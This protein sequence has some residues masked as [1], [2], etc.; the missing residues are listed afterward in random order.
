LKKVIC[1][2]LPTIFVTTVIASM[3]TLFVSAATPYVKEP[4]DSG[5]VGTGV[6]TTSVIQSGTCTTDGWS[7]TGNYTASRPIYQEK[8]TGQP[9][10]KV[11]NIDMSSTMLYTTEVLR[12]AH[13]TN[14]T[15]FSGKVS[16]SCDVQPVINTATNASG[17]IRLYIGSLDDS[18]NTGSQIGFGIA[19]NSIVIGTN[20]F[21]SSTALDVQ[22]DTFTSSSPSWLRFVMVVDNSVSPKTVTYTVKN[23]TNGKTY[24]ENAIFDKTYAGGTNIPMLSI[25]Y[26]NKVAGTQYLRIDNLT[27]TYLTPTKTLSPSMD[28]YIDY[29]NKT[30]SHSTSKTLYLSPV[31][32]KFVYRSTAPVSYG[33]I[34]FDTSGWTDDDVRNATCIKIKLMTASD[35]DET[36]TGYTGGASN[37]TYTGGDYRLV[38][39][40]N[41]PIKDVLQVLGLQ[42][43]ISLNGTTETPINYK[44]SWNANTTW[45]T[46]GGLKLNTIGNL[47]RGAIVDAVR[48]NTTYYLDVTDYVVFNKLYDSDLS[49]RNYIAFKLQKMIQGW[50]WTE[51]RFG[52]GFSIHSS[53]ADVVDNRPAII[54]YQNNSEGNLQNLADSY[55]IGNISAVI[56][57]VFLPKS[58]ND[59]TITWYSDSPTYITNDGVVTQGT[60]DKS[61]CLTAVFAKDDITVIKK[62]YGTVKA[63]V[64]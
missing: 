46:A 28:T 25:S 10:D 39:P 6:F 12:Y 17:Y 62:Y 51:N 42:Q 18:T 47:L 56:G 50:M 34:Q 4:F 33:L 64:P 26:K 32:N 16:F 44:T 58:I 43:G 24:A 14:A 35:V 37:E 63:L 45:D 23:L 41:A 36:Q 59:T 38:A 49:N 57:D 22:G 48:K 8:V 11:A 2:I 61:F 15:D 1:K 9:D 27:Y 21:L 3:T 31:Q 54:L 19:S 55:K 13:V 53:K 29:A 40:G 5:T 30:T 60:A 7:F 52:N 20:G